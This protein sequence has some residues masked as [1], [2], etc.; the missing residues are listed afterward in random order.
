MTFKSNTYF[1]IKIHNYIQ[2]AIKVCITIPVKIYF[3]LQQICFL[4]LLPSFISPFC[5]FLYPFLCLSS[6][7]Y[8]P[9]PYFDLWPRTTE[10]CQKWK[11]KLKHVPGTR[12]RGLNDW[13][14]TYSSQGF[15][16]S[17]CCSWIPLHC[18]PGESESEC[19]LYSM[20]PVPSSCTL[21]R[22][23]SLCLQV[24]KKGH[25]KGMNNG[26]GERFS[27]GRRKRKERKLK[28]EAKDGKSS[29][30]FST[31]THSTVATVGQCVYWFCNLWICFISKA[32]ILHFPRL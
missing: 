7:R 9:V 16:P 22:P 20:C 24:T 30:R 19:G 26:E 2:T 11:W 28:G 1:Y 25:K 13:R 31:S 17:I 32:I 3:F 21:D 27:D 8:F 29:L 15:I 12:K 5:I 14:N 4:L 23:L 6:D 18:F 10:S